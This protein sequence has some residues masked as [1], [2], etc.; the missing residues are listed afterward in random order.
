MT[1]QIARFFYASLNPCHRIAEL[2]ERLKML[3]NYH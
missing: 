3:K 1:E 2:Q